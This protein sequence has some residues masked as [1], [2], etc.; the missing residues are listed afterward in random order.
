MGASSRYLNP[1]PS[2]P[3]GDAATKLAEALLSSEIVRKNQTVRLAFSD[4]F[5]S[6]L[7]A[8]A[9]IAL[10]NGYTPRRG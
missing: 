8:D 1:K 2:L 10:R 3:A 5:K 7:A 9:L 4:P 6:R